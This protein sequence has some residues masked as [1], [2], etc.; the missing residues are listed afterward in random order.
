MKPVKFGNGRIAGFFGIFIFSLIFLALLFGRT[1][2]RDPV[3]LES[4]LPEIEGFRLTESLQNYYPE[5]LFEYI[6]GAAEIYLAYD[7]KQL[8][9]AQYKKID[10]PDSLAVEVYDM[11]DPKNSFGIY[12]AE[13]Y[14]DSQFLPLGTQ[15][16][17]EEGALNFLAGAYYV[18]LLCFDCGDRADEILVTFSKDIASRVGDKSGFPV[19]L[20][21]FPREGMLPNT[22]KFIL[23]NV[24]GYRFLH[25]G[26]LA[27][28]ETK[29]L[30]FDCFLIEGKNSEESQDMLEQYLEAKGA[31]GVQK[32]SSGYRIKDRYY[33]NIY[34]A[35]VG[36]YL[37]GVM[38]IKEGFEEVGERYLRSWIQSLK[39]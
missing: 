33:H 1:E 32:I 36:R 28:Y 37:C 21:S 15:G 19:L 13:R 31:S 22:E 3:S 10:A 16:Y 35:Q 26:Y 4:F 8:I 38:K 30:S 9:V 11:G 6:D 2:E 5:T 7:F 25:D 24:M 39:Q 18:K 14:P 27:N 17:V 20:K 29:D 12:S 23:R 34:L